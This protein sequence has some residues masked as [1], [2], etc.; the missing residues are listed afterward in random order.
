MVVQHN[1]Q[2]MNSNRMLGVTQK[3]LSGSTEKLSSGYKINR[4]A[5]N[6]AGLSISEKMRK[7][8]RGLTQ[9]SINAEDG[10][11]SVQTAE[12]ALQEVTDMLQRLNEL[13][14]QAANGTNS[15][16][17]R[18]YI[19]DEIDQLVTEIDRVS[20]TTK[21]NEIYL[22]KG[23]ETEESSKMY[24]INYT[25]TYAMN[26]GSNFGVYDP[27]HPG[28]AGVP[29]N[30]GVEH[31]IKYTGNDP[32]YTVNDAKALTAGTKGTPVTAEIVKKGDEFTKYLAS[33]NEDKAAGASTTGKVSGA[34]KNM[35]YGIFKAAN[36]SDLK[37]NSTGTNADLKYENGV[38]SALPKNGVAGSADA[39]IMDMQNN[40]IIRIPGGEDLSDYMSVENTGGGMTV[41]MK[42][43]Y[44]LLEEVKVDVHADGSS[45]RVDSHGTSVGKVPGTS[46]ASRLKANQEAT[47]IHAKTELQLMK[48]DAKLYDANGHVVS[49]IALRKYFDKNGEYI[50]GLFY[51]AQAS[52]A[53]YRDEDGKHY[54]GYDKISRYIT[55]NYTEVAADLNFK[56][57]VGADSDR[58]NKISANIRSTSS[59]SLGVNRLRR[60]AIGIVDMDGEN[61][62]DAIDV[63]AEAIQKV[64]T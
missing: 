10:I 45:C 39:Y 28:G 50:G 8:I 16:T 6:A 1:M 35:D 58:T 54:Y 41:R 4:A 12:G 61:A 32:L 11:S 18:S 46:L 44:R 29:R 37:V 56:L 5:D 49:G 13:A 63:I 31:R 9:A 22:L 33:V 51:D 55:K 2:A 34:Y 36:A 42:D 59:A 64:S 27:N 57:H 19:Q 40:C 23:D 60:N 7:Q 26:H 3:T 53:V 52:N 15:V 24:M 38:L 20:E 62:T 30:D 43:Q 21:F 25:F 47:D 17:D 14:V 48:E